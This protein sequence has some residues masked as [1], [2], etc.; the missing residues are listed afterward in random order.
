MERKIVLASS[1]P[2]RIEM[3]KQNGYDPLVMPADIEENIPCYN[4]MTDVVMFLALKKAQ[5]VN[6]KIAETDPDFFSSHPL[7]IASD[8]IVY[9][10]GI[11]GKPKDYEDG[12][13]MLKAL[14]GDVHYVV[15]GVCM[16]YAGEKKIKCFYD[17]TKVFF[18]DYTDEELS[19]YLKTDEPYDKA[20]GYA[21]QGT[22]K[23][24]IDHYEGSYSNVVGFPW[25]KIEKELNL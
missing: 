18:K 22:F 19:E 20:G 23:K 15:S 6:D 11:M 4:S 24:Y 2:R 13:R 10:D 25:E 16:I 7:I 12:F 9:K 14:R 5:W 17:V 8:T 1:S 3:M 21:I